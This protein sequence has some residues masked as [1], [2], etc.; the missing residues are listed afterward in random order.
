MQLGLQTKPPSIVG[1]YLWRTFQR[2]IN[3]NSSRFKDIVLI[4]GRGLEGFAP[5]DSI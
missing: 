3:E 4:W 5:N 1:S 2:R